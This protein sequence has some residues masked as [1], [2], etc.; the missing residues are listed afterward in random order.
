MNNQSITIIAIAGASASGKS[1]FAETLYKE[2]TTELGPGLIAIISEDAYYKDLQHLPVEERA[3]QN[4]DHPDAFEHDLMTRQLLQLR[5]GQAIEC[6][7]YCYK[8]HSRKE[9]TETIQPAPIIIVEGIL[10]LNDE[11]L[12]E[13]FD[14]SVFMDSPLDI[15][16]LRRITRDV[17]ERGRAIDGIAQQYEKTVRPMFYK[18]IEPSKHYADLIVTRGGKNRIAMSIIK[19]KIKHLLGK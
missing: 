11:I 3:Q 19:A 2:L 17:N 9:E 7:T 10:L 4:F 12:R 18:F 1:L 5:E 15:C 16:L 13:Q 8:T 14:I 6:P